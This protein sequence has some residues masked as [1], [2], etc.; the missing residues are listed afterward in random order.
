MLLPVPP[1]V[2]SAVV[3]PPWCLRCAGQAGYGNPIDLYLKDAILEDPPTDG[4]AHK[5]APF[6][7]L[8]WDSNR[9]SES[10]KYLATGRLLRPRASMACCAASK[11]S[12]RPVGSDGFD[13]ITIA[14]VFRS[15]RL[16]I[17]LSSIKMLG[18]CGRSVCENRAF[19]LA[20]TRALH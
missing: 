12:C 2:G 14:P 16:I 17:G 1:L 19:P 6:Y 15:S 4:G 8:P 11:S 13:W 18:G 3:A 7:R 20:P 10:S 5:A 9:S